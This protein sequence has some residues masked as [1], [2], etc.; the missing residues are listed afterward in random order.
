MILNRLFSF[1]NNQILNRVVSNSFWN[2]FGNAT[3][4]IISLVTLMI[5][6]R[7]LG[8]S[9]S[10]K[11]GIIYST[12]ITI[13]IFTGLGFGLACTKYIADFRNKDIFKTSQIVLATS[14][15]NLVFNFILAIL[16]YLFSSKIST[17]FFSTKDLVENFK[18]SI[19]LIL[20]ISFS[21]H[22]ISI[23]SGFEHFKINSFLNLIKGSI[24]FLV[25][26]FYYNSLTFNKIIFGYYIANISTIVFAQIY[27]NK[28]IIVNKRTLDFKSLFLTLK[29]ISNFSFYSLINSILWPLIVWI[30]N[31]LLIRVPNGF[32]YMSVLNIIRQWQAAIN[33]IPVA[34]NTA[35][36]PIFSNVFSES[37]EKLKS[38]I[39]FTNKINL[40]SV[41]TTTLF[42]IIFSKLILSF[43]GNL[44]THYYVDFITI[45][46]ATAFSLLNSPAGSLILSRGYIRQAISINIVGNILYL[47][48]LFFTINKYTLT[49]IGV[50]T[51]ISNLLGTILIIN[52]SH[53]YLSLPKEVKNQIILSLIVLVSFLI[54]I[55]T[56]NIK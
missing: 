17:V 49:S 30:S 20:L 35:I 14:I 34:L 8:M 28:K 4:Q 13:S 10:G 56:Y 19:F 51:L 54:I 44:Y 15:I 24:I 29:N 40:I 46:V 47:L 50:S 27:I 36:L 42:L 32:S 38:T 31:L 39:I 11:F 6:T 5:I 12:I 53:K 33:F 37:P 55:I 16:F 41:W 2:L 26:L 23:L 1:R 22:Q 3:S 43:Y 7:G 25:V 48:I 21:N 52:Y 45:M 18:V 9:E